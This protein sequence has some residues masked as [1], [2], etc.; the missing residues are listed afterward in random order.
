[1]KNLYLRCC[2]QVGDTTPSFE[3]RYDLSGGVFVPI[4]IFVVLNAE[5]TDFVFR[6]SHLPAHCFWFLE[7]SLRDLFISEYSS[8]R[9][10]YGCHHLVAMS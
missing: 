3:Q 5:C 10:A 4:L 9:F 2:M 7:E 6:F 8:R 1:M